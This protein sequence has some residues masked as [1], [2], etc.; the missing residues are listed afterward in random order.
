MS[1][2]HIQYQKHLKTY[3]QENRKNPTPEEKKLWFEFL[4]Q[5]PFQF[6]RQKSFGCYIVDF[7]CSSA[8]LVIEIDGSQHFTEEGKAWDDNRTAYLNSIGLQ[9]LRF[10]NRQLADEFDGVCCMIDA[11]I[12]TAVYGNSVEE[13][14]SVSEQTR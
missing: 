12:E 5:H 1:E 6:R 2:K 9:V 14:S 3:A 11:V 8:K 4:R 10:T 13:T 7:Y